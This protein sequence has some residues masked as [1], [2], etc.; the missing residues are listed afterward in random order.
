MEATADNHAYISLIRAL[1][2]G[3]RKSTLAVGPAIAYSSHSAYGGSDMEAYHLRPKT[4]HLVAA[5]ASLIRTLV[6]AGRISEDASQTLS[7]AR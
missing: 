4:L 1:I 7:R 5:A 3:S 2:S 6:G